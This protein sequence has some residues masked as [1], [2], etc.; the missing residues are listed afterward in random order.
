[1][2]INS[3]FLLRSNINNILN[4]LKNNLSLDINRSYLELVDDYIPKYKVYIEEVID[5]Y[6]EQI[7]NKNIDKVFSFKNCKYN[8]KKIEIKDSYNNNG[9]KH[10]KLIKYNISEKKKNKKNNKKYNKSLDRLYKTNMETLKWIEDNIKT[11]KYK[12][13]VIALINACMDEFHS[14]SLYDSEN[15]MEHLRN[16]YRY[17]YIE[18]TEN[19]EPCTPNTKLEKKEYKLL[20]NKKWREYSNYCDLRHELISK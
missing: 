10:L 4:I 9:Y 1:M 5:E 17:I 8:I 13:R 14:Y 6:Y 3:V 18:L 7:Y 12:Y 2:K 11:N 15:K 19:I 16:V 20:L